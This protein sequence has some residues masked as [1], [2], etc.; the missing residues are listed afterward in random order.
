MY[1]ILHI[2][3]GHCLKNWGNEDILY[4]TRESASGEIKHLI[5][6]HK[7]GSTYKSEWNKCNKDIGEDISEEEFEIIRIGD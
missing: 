7:T 6:R 1:K 2:P 3:T 4:N 5:K